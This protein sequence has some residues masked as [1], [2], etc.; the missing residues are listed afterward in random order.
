MRLTFR[1]A[2]AAGAAA[3][4]AAPALAQHANTST[5]IND[6][7]QFG[8][9]FANMNVV[10]RSNTP[11]VTSS[12]L[13]AGN[14]ASGANL[15][16]N[17]N[18]RSRQTNTGAAFAGASIDAANVTQAVAVAT[19]QGN[20]GQIQ[21]TN[22]KLDLDGAQTS[23]PADANA[24]AR[25]KLANAQSV[26]AGA[27][28]AANNA[29]T[30]ADH[31]DMNV[32]LAQ[33]SAG[34]VYSVTD[35]DACCT[36]A[37][38]AGATAAA[39]GYSSSSTTSTVTADIT[40]RSTGNQILASTDVYQNRGYDVTAATTAAANSAT[41]ANQWGYTS[42]RGRQA[43]TSGVY[44]ETSVTLGAW[45]G[46][47]TASSHGVG[48]TILA[49]NIGS[50]LAVDIGQTND[51][52]V[53][54]NVSFDGVSTDGGAVIAASTAIG[55]GFTGYV[56][57]YCG[58]ASVSGAVTQTNTGNVSSTGVITTTGAGQVFGTAS[59]IGNSATFITTTRP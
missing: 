12:A 8:D 24:V 4:L 40:Q 18:L 30:G 13:A 56:C 19:A 9:V 21:T 53:I 7:I 44:A 6:Q 27:S 22:G 15:A 23:G 37:T 32:R 42:L 16:G 36:G 5:A 43:N 52:S 41:I 45:S 51:G 39:N 46:T 25:V 28:A 14:A 47:A 1:L 29:A 35:V 59:A 10:T 20:T 54:S 33:S 26:S 57:S 3:L 31:G 11:S 17:M 55:N 34:S 2:L 48:N 58:D 49:T 50:D 38:N